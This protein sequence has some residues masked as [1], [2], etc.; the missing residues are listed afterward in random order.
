[1]REPSCVHAQA[2]HV[3]H[4]DDHREATARA[5]AHPY[6]AADAHVVGAPAT[7][8]YAAPDAHVVGAPATEPYAAPDAVA[9]AVADQDH[10]GT[11]AVADQDHIGTGAVA[12]RNLHPTHN[13]ADDLS[14]TDV[15]APD[16]H[17][18]AV[19]LLADVPSDHHRD[20]AAES[21]D[22][23][24]SYPY[25]DADPNHDPSDAHPDPHHHS[26]HAFGDRHPYAEP[27]SHQPSS[28]ERPSHDRAGDNHPY[29]RLGDHDHHG[30]RVAHRDGVSHPVD[31]TAAGSGHRPAPTRASTARRQWSR[32]VAH[33]HRSAHPR[34]R[35]GGDVADTRRRR[36]DHGADP[37][38]ATPAASGRLSHPGC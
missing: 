9:E 6:P 30:Q 38:G 2:H 5:D 4:L 15:A 25:P 26:S 36:G 35:P 8:P 3:T 31:P 27:S 22:D 34:A 7:E 28:G 11:G 29:D 23:G 12:D 21:D 10:I 32:R 19:H 13:H 17:V 18:P 16:I 14:R 33:Q 1:M 20:S 24:S 37:A